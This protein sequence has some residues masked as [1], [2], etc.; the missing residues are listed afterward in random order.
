[1]K[2]NH[3]VV[4]VGNIS[5][6]DSQQSISYKPDPLPRVDK[7]SFSWDNSTMHIMSAVFQFSGKNSM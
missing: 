7:G 6:T 5:T 4:Y 3:H 1:M 2:I